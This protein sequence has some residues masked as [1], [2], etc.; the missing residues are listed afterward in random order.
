MH[1]WVHTWFGNTGAATWSYDYG[2]P[3]YG[4]QP[5]EARG[6][7]RFGGFSSGTYGAS[8]Y[9][10]TNW[11]VAPPMLRA[12]APKS[13]PPSTCATRVELPAV[14]V[15]PAAAARSEP[16][17]LAP[18]RAN[19]AVSRS[20]GAL[21]LLTAQLRHSIAPQHR[22][23]TDPQ[24][25]S[26]GENA[27]ALL[28]GAVVLGLRSDTERMV[29]GTRRRRRLDVADNLLHFN[30]MHIL[31]HSSTSGDV[32]A[33]DPN[34]A[35]LEVSSL[36]FCGSALPVTDT[37]TAAAAALGYD[38]GL[39]AAGG[40]SEKSCQ[41]VVDF[42]VTA[43]FVVP[44]IVLATTRG[45]NFSDTFAVSTRQVSNASVVLNVLRV[46]T[47]NE[48]SSDGWAQELEIEFIALGQ[49][50]RWP[51]RGSG[52]GGGR[53]GIGLSPSL[54]A[55]AQRFP[56]VLHQA[57]VHVGNHSGE[58]P[59]QIVVVPFSGAWSKKNRLKCGSSAGAA[60]K[61]DCSR[62]RVFAMAR[63]APGTDY[64]DVFSVVVCA[65]DRSGFSA[66]ITRL[67]ATTGWDQE[68]ELDYAVVG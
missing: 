47:V 26:A 15:E 44:P 31:R 22:A 7:R 19:P 60:G 3:S 41:I 25:C 52:G 35:R 1:R 65:V 28:L 18:K 29:P 21:H 14:V 67:D 59:V 16:A 53:G 10:Y 56:G 9:S 2:G 54:T 36:A 5:W 42:S 34:T 32:V 11:V 66:R 48:F 17:W 64:D 46:D 68:L 6:G 57:R 58:D 39:V 38:A 12:L 20:A 33:N 8:S 37:G 13:L 30:A 51:T 62:L 55:R 45:Q 63:N 24:W 23:A 4:G 49:Q 43:G 50:L 40:S 27:S 61:E